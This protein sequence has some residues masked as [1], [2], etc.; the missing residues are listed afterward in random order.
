MYTLQRL[1]QGTTPLSD[2]D[3]A[4]LVH[5]ICKGLG[6]VVPCREFMAAWNFWMTPVCVCDKMQQQPMR[7]RNSI[8]LVRLNI[9]HYGPFS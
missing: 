7:K 9:L 4:T 5:A 3:T 2:D 1:T 6:S 8:V